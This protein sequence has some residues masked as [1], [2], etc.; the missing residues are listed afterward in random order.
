M[1]LVGAG[2]C[3]VERDAGVHMAAI[4]G[5]VVICLPLRGGP[6]CDLTDIL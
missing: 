2:S 6:K 4:A 3:E 5:G 1:W